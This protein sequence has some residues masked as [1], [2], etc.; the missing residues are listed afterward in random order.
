MQRKKPCDILFQIYANKCIED[1]KVLVTHIYDSSNAILAKCI[2]LLF[3]SIN[4]PIIR[5]EQLAVN[6][7]IKMIVYSETRDLALSRCF[8]LV[9]TL[10]C[11]GRQ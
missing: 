5:S 11:I 8:L 3:I 7:T 9:K 4:Q 10:L 6:V 2:G 1:F